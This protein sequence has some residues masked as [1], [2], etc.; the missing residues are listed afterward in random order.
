MTD[1]M[2]KQTNEVLTAT[3]L[4]HF[5]NVQAGTLLLFNSWLPHMITKNQS[6]EKT[7]FIHFTLGQ[8]RRFI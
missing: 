8:R 5:N 6:E 7:K 2:S 1:L 4:I 3:P